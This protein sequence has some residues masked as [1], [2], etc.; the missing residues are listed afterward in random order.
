[1]TDRSDLLALVYHHDE[2][3]EMDLAARRVA[4][5]NLV[6]E[7]GVDDVAGSVA[8]LAREVDGY[9][10][11]TELLEDE[12]VTDVLVNGIEGMLVERR[13]ELV[14][15]PSPFSDRAEL[16][17]WTERTLSVAGGRVDASCPIGDARLADGSRIHAVFPP[18]APRGPLVSIRCA[19]RSPRSL[20]D[21]VVL[22]LVTDEQAASLQEFVTDKRC[23]VISGATGVGKT[24]LLNA[25][26]MQVPN[27]ERVV[28][29]EEL[30]ELR[31]G[32]NA[33]SLVARG[34]NSEGRG[35]VTLEE[36]VRASLRMRPDRIIVGE[37]RGAEA[38]PALWA[39]STGHAGS[40]LSVHARSA[41]HGRTRL[42][43]LALR[44]PE[45]PS[46][47]ALTREVHDVVDVI[48]H[49]ERR[50]AKRVVT[51]LLVRS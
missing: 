46:E 38:L 33:V 22:G 29:I 23:I 31:P 48:V 36:L 17:A 26:L 35:E 44:A 21:L 41:T 8:I 14:A 9:G 16:C 13:G 37:V 34:A 20:A 2:L 24:T 15:M 10:P 43:A 39:M 42:V 6:I 4:L 45:S 19:P 40:M 11:I 50:E 7:A 12:D 1:M 32:T 3:A 25:L 47:E 51:E 18:I 5:R 30:P 49:I 28:T 27:T